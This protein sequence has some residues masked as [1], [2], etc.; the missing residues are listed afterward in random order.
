MRGFENLESKWLWEL[1]LGGEK[2]FVFV[3]VVFCFLA[4]RVFCLFF[5]SVLLSAIRQIVALWM[6]LQ[7]THLLL[8]SRID[9]F[10]FLLST[11]VKS[12]SM[13][14]SLSSDLVGML[15]W[16]VVP[17]PQSALKFLPI[18]PSKVRLHSASPQSSPVFKLFVVVVFLH[19]NVLHL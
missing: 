6:S 11:M 10:F 15:S 5:L 16:P 18:S 19:F 9:S 8:D 4:V 12:V 3:S 17:G 13:S 14:S 7:M 1:I 2:D